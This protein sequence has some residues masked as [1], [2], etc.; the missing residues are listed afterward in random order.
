MI[1]KSLAKICVS[2]I[3]QES[4]F[5]LSNQ[6]R[7]MTNLQ[8]IKDYTKSLGDR[9]PIFENKQE[10]KDYIAQTFI[11]M[12]N[13]W[14]LT[15]ND[16]RRTKLNIELNQFTRQYSIPDGTYTISKNRSVKRENSLQ[17]IS[18]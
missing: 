15:V 2:S 4:N 6:N 8:D 5:I 9:R 14:A 12:L 3:I 10:K 13:E 1:Q 11:E 18:N 16:T 7:I 17:P